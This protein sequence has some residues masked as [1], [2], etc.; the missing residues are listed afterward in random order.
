MRV[1]LPELMLLV[2]VLICAEMSW[3]RHRGLQL[4]VG[5]HLCEVC[6]A[7]QGAK[8]A[9]GGVQLPLHLHPQC[10]EAG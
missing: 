1:S 3:L 2:W 10:P 7:G 5:R 8:Q 4:H 9:A 6:S